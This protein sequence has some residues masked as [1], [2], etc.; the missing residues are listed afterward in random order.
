MKIKFLST[1]TFSVLLLASCHK[2]DDNNIDTSDNT[3][4]FS[5]GIYQTKNRLVGG[6]SWEGT[7]QI[8][9]YML[10]NGQSE[11]TEDPKNAHYKAD[12][13]GIATS[14]SP[15]S[16]ENT[17]YYPGDQN[18]KVDFIAYYP[19][20]D[21]KDYIYPVKTVDQSA[22][23][24]IDLI[25]AFANNDSVGYDKTSKMVNLEFHHKLTNI[26][27][28]IKN[29]DGIE[30]EDL[31]NLEITFKGLDTEATYHITKNTLTLGQKVADIKAYS[32]S[33]GKN[34]ELIVIPQTGSDTALIEFKLNNKRNDI[35]TYSISKKEFL[36]GKKYTYNATIKR[37]E[38]V[39]QGTIKPWDQEGEEEIIVD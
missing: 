37:N 11:T 38:V 23:S 25:R 24:S 36:E 21:I 31:K 17:L 7:E 14:F 34:Y 13:A 4:K 33:K 28:N 35:F 15:V 12:K 2:S 20:T 3:V 32:S 18:Q 19:F 22:Q 5:S 29:G 9:I 16:K 27:L 1:I 26:V 39:I 30:L 8:G 10:K 6:E